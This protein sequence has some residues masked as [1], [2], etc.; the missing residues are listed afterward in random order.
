MES[1]PFAP[2]SE[3]SEDLGVFGDAVLKKKGFLH[4]VILFT[5]PSNWAGQPSSLGRSAGT[6]DV[7]GNETPLELVYN[8]WWFLQRVHLNGQLVWWTISWTT[9]HSQ[10]EIDLSQIP[11][12]APIGSPEP[13]GSHGFPEHLRIEIS[14][15]RGLRIRR[16]RVWLDHQIRYDEIC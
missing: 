9:I 10:V 4:R 16:F 15:I 6:A 7:D 5:S 12:L 11:D 13:V 1:N 2:T 8:G 14:F 3:I